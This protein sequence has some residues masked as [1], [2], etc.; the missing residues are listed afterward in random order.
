MRVRHH[1]TAG[2]V[3]T[4]GVARVSGIS[5]A[6]H[7]TADSRGRGHYQRQ[8]KHEPQHQPPGHSGHPTR[9]GCRARLSQWDRCSGRGVGGAG[10]AE[11]VSTKLRVPVSTDHAPP[12]R[13]L[14]LLAQRRCYLDDQ[15]PIGDE[16]DVPGV[17]SHTIRAL[18][19]DRMLGIAVQR[20]IELQTDLVKL[21]HRCPAFGA[22]LASWVCAMA[23]GAARISNASTAATT[24]NPLVTTA[25]R[26]RSGCR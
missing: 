14:A 8:A 25:L 26:M 5:S 3:V 19:P 11:R 9:G 17:P 22:L 15:L 21:G 7:A 23:V 24:R 1:S 10:V 4:R 6:Y 20:A 13:I 16:S 18:D 2:L 12:H